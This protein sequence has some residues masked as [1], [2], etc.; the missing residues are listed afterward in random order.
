MNEVLRHAPIT[1][2]PAAQ[3][4]AKEDT[5]IG[6]YF[7]EQHSPV[8]I[9]YYSLTRDPSVWD[10]PDRFEPGRFIAAD[11]RLRKDLQNKFFPFGLGSRRCIGEH[12]GRMQLYLLCANLVYHFTVSPPA[13]ERLDVGAYPGV[14]MVPK[15]F[16][17]V[18]TPR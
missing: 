11:G 5:T 17:V 1:P 15:P 16:R 6:R 3:Y 8:I 10:E 7:I 18:A 2:V 9:N 14:F 12:I 13:G 4:K